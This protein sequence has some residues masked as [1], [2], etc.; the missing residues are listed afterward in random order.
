MK[1]GVV[2]YSPPKNKLNSEAFMRNISQFKAGNPLYLISDDAAWNPSQLIPNPEIVGKR[3]PWAINNLIFFESLIVARK[4]G[5]DYFLYVESDSRVGCDGYDAAIFD[6]FFKRY[7]DGITCAGS[8]VAWDI[9][10]GGRDFAMKIIEEAWHYQSIGDLPMA[11]YSSKHPFDASGGCIY[12]NG[13][14]AVY[15]TEAICTVFAGFDNDLLSYSKRNTAYDLALG[16]FLWNYHGPRAVDHVGFLTRCYSGYGN[17]I[18]TEAERLQMLKDG[19][20]L[21]VHQIKGA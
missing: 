4:T 7:P 6:E 19:S 9:C 8:P 2:A 15:K 21:C 17:T 5:L 14:L 1:L 18:T 16:K 12:P 11:I 20:K 13:S 3:P 10:A